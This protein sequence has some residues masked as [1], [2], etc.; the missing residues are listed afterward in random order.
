MTKKMSKAEIVEAL[1]E[2]FDVSRY[3]VLKDLTLE[4][5]YAELERRIFAYKAR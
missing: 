4:Q 2:W 3:D 1:S 5:I